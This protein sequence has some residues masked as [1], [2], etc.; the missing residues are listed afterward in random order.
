MIIRN[1]QELSESFSK[2]IH[3][4]IP[5]DYGVLSKIMTY[6][7]DFL[8]KYGVESTTSEEN[9]MHI[10]YIGL[11]DYLDENQDRALALLQHLGVNKIEF[12]NGELP[13]GVLE[14]HYEE[15]TVQ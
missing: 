14:V 7:V 12:Y 5:Q 1:V 11:Y 13:L 2:L 9:A 15:E 6:Y 3:I 4:L 8:K 10:L